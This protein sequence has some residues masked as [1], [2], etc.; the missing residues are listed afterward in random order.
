MTTNPDRASAKIYTFPARG[1]FAAGQREETKPSLNFTSQ[2]M[3]AVV[4]E[5]WYHDEAIKEE[6]PRK[7]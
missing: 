3:K 2:A 5:A 6:Q 7:H 4:G 1:R